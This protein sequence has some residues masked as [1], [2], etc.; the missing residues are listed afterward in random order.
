M[1][2]QAD[3][4]AVCAMLQNK[5][6]TQWKKDSE[7][8]LGYVASGNNHCCHDHPEVRLCGDINFKCLTIT[9]DS[10]EKLNVSLQPCEVAD[11]WQLK[12]LCRSIEVI[13]INTAL[14]FFILNTRITPRLKRE[15]A[16]AEQW[17]TT[18]IHS[19]RRTSAFAGF[20]DQPDVKYC[21]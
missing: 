10:V 6:Y 5:Q 13:C 2:R 1:F 11:P 21:V 18:G 16:A 4:A 14:L 9:A 8:M 19:L 3:T 15:K 17:D 20:S 12:A 7:N